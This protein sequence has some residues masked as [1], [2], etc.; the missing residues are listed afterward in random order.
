MDVLLYM[1]YVA[2][3]ETDVETESIIYIEAVRLCH[4]VT[5]SYMA[6]NYRIRIPKKQV[7]LRQQWPPPQFLNSE[8]NPKSE[9]PSP[10]SDSKE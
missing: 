4:K 8:L 10:A 2:F 5:E 6:V 1:Y 9:S 7:V 3:F